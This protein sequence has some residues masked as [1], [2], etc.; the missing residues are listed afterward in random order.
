M[1]KIVG[2][3][4]AGLIIAG[5][6]E[7]PLFLGNALSFI[8]VLAGLA[9]IDVSKLFAHTKKV[10]SKPESTFKSLQ[11]G[12]KYVRQTPAVLMIIAVVGIVSLFGINFNVIEPVIA[13]DL[14]HQGAQG[15]GFLSSSFGCGALVGALW[16]A[17]GNKNPSFKKMLTSAVCFCITLGLV[18]LSHW[19]ILSM[20]LAVICGFT[21][22]TFTA[23]ANTT[24]QTVTPDHL[25]GR[26]MGVYMLVF[27]GS[28]PFGNLFTGWLTG[29]VGITFALVVNALFSL[30]AATIGLIK[31]GPAEKDLRRAIGFDE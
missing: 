3:G 22:I 18:G 8:P 10:S 31:R 30:I 4:I 16:I 12:L 24:L 1:A 26:I 9:L 29:L 14:L 6:G 19:Y 21:M 23:T 20:A 7:G 17:W 13:T 28:T 25:R 5:F 27:N 2:P 11:Q 15:F